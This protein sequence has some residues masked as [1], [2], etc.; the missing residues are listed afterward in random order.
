MAY[1]AVSS[2]PDVSN[3]VERTGY[4]VAALTLL[5]IPGSEI[6]GVM[7]LHVGM[8]IGI[9]NHHGHDLT[10][11]GAMELVMNIGATV[12]VSLVG[13]KLATTAAKFILPGLGGI[14]AAPFMFASTLALGAVA[15]TWFAKGGNVSEAEMKAVYDRVVRGAKSEFKADRMKD[16]EAMEQARKAAA[17]ETSKAAPPGPEEDAVSRLKRAKELLD[18][19]L[20]EQSEYDTL[21][22][23]I[24]DSL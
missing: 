24:L 3:L 23:R 20:L 22:Q 7:P 6:F 18:A 12:G 1:F 5:P 13:S 9:G 21:K 17:A 11:E 19:G 8:V 4:A 2:N 14:I 16:P 15:D 10:R